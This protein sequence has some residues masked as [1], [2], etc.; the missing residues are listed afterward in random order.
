MPTE[1][2]TGFAFLIGLAGFFAIG[3]VY[4]ILNQALSVQIAP[5]IGAFVNSSVT[6]ATLRSTA[7][8][9]ISRSL[10]IW[11]ITPYFISFLILFYIVITALRNKE[12]NV[13]L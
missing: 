7:N 4:I 10:I 13:G 6:N 2:S 9:D 12:E 8:A 1:T 3:L 11:K 5:S